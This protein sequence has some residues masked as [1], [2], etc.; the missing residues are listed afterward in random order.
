MLMILGLSNTLN[1]TDFEGSSHYSQ[2]NFTGNSN[3]HKN[4]LLRM[5]ESLHC[6]L[7]YGVLLLMY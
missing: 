4:I 3:L 2:T 1:Q 7:I 5:I 6:T